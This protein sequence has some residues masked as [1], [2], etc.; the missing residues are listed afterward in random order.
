[1]VV[2]LRPWAVHG[3]A[4]AVESTPLETGG[5]VW[6]K[7]HREQGVIPQT[8]SDPEAG[9]SQSGWHGWWDGWKLHLAVTGGSVWIPLAAELTVAK[10][11]A[12]AVAPLLREQLPWDVR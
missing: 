2:L 11:G 8:S 5:G 10:R 6:P 7:T 12:T 1:L 9:G 4:V 3:R